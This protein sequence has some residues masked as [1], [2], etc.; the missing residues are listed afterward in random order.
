MCSD[1]NTK[2]KPAEQSHDLLTL[3]EQYRAVTSGPSV[4]CSTFSEM[5]VIVS[6]QSSSLNLQIAI[7]PSSLQEA[8]SPA[9]F[10]FQ[11]TL[12]TSW[13]WALV[14]WAT[15]ENT[16]WSGSVVSSSLNTRTASSPQAVA[17][18]PVSRH[19]NKRQSVLDEKFRCIKNPADNQPTPFDSVKINTKS[20]PL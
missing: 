10:G 19:L 12:L 5:P 7:S 11:A 1:I 14:T 8:R 13:L 4:A 18:A 16:G 3:N 20:L 15:S 9:S 17:R 6:A 2:F